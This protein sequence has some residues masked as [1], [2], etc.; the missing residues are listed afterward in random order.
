MSNGKSE[1]G[2]LGITGE[3]RGHCTSQGNADQ[4]TCQHRGK[5]RGAPAQYETEHA[6]PQHFVNKGDRAR[7]RDQQEDRGKTGRPARR[8][9]LGGGRVAREQRRGRKD[10]GIGQ[11]AEI[12]CLAQAKLRQQEKC[13]GHCTADGPG[14]ID[15]VE[16]ANS[17]THLVIGLNS[18]PSQQGEGRAHQGRTGDQHQEGTP[19][20]KQRS[21]EANAFRRRI[22]PPEPIHINAH[23]AANRKGNR[24]RSQ[25]NA[26]FDHPVGKNRATDAMRPAPRQCGPQRQPGHVGSQDRGHRQFGC[27]KYKSKLTGPSGFI[28]K[29]SKTRYEKTEL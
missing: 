17:R 12:D 13:G 24:Q 29:R 9:T 19:Q 5:R 28:Q 11:C 3:A 2:T 14:S 26:Q 25:A 15:R 10:Q 4:E 23:Q 8:F 7:D 27:A 21:G 22:Q 16:V 1:T 20:M 6:N 18:M